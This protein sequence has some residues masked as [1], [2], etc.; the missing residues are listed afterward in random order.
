VPPVTDSWRLVQSLADTLTP[1]EPDQFATRESAS[2]WLHDAGLLPADAG[3]SN[4]EHNALLRLRDALRDVRAARS[5]GRADPDAAARLTRALADGRIVVTLGE[6]GTVTLASSAR[7][8]YPNAVA[9]IAIA[10]ANSA[11]GGVF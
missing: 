7:S 9:A 4:S 10:I 5:T 1:S 11:A 6:D 3:L 2:D 8:V